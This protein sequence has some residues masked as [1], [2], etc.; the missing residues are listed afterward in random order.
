[1]SLAAGFAAYVYLLNPVSYVSHTPYEYL[2]AS[3]PAAVVAAIVYAAFTRLLVVPA[4]RG[5]YEE[6]QAGA[7]RVAGEPA[8]A[9]M[10]AQR[11]EG[12]SSSARGGSA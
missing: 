9:R 1:L 7:S 8:G 6:T 5:G 3:I 2:S 11:P 4:R 12:G 10:S